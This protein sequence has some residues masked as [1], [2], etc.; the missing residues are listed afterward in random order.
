MITGLILEWTFHRNHLI[1][2]DFLFEDDPIYSIQ[3]VPFD[4]RN[5]HPMQKTGE[6]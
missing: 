5:V 6:Q 2:G 3:Q 4:K 1:F